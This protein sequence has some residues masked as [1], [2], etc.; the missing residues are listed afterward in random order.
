[1]RNRAIGGQVP[2]GNTEMEY[3]S[4]GRGSQPLVMIPGLSDGL[5]TVKGTASQ[6]ARMFRCFAHSHTVYMLSRPN[7]LPEV[8]TTRAMAADYAAAMQQLGIA[9]ADVFG[10]SQGGMVAQW[11]AIDHPQLVSKLVL[12]V[13]L[14]RQNSTVQTVVRRWI[15]LAEQ[16]DYA[17]LFI[18]TMEHSFTEAYLKKMRWLYPIFSRVGK[19]QSL[20]RLILQAHACI[21]HD[22]HAQLCRI[23][24]PTF[25][26]GTGEDK[27][28]GIDGTEIAA[29][30]AG[31]QLLIYEHQGHMPQSEAN[32]FNAQ[33]VRFFA[34]HT[35]EQ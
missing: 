17:R 3:I 14:S 12:A 8:Y 4:F 18:D 11:L 10:I 22:A 21:T 9:Q 16:D 13:T 1:M 19:P 15:A 20:N 29:E 31:S 6:M 32:D 5:K 28:V 26:I 30:I 23:A 7:Q 24:C 35:E 27:V 34:Q 25:V 33:V 2:V